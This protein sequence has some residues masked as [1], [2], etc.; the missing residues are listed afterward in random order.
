MPVGTLSISYPSTVQVL[1]VFD[2]AGLFA[3]SNTTDAGNSHYLKDVP[4]SFHAVQR[5][6]V[7]IHNQKTWGLS[8]G[9]STTVAAKSLCIYYNTNP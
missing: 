8:R 9:V 4:T 5:L 7:G 2:D 6:L 1:P 3:L